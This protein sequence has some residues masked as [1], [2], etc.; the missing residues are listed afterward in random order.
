MKKNLCAAALCLLLLAGCG[1]S[2]EETESPTPGQALESIAA[3]PETMK[4]DV[5]ESQLIQ[6]AL[7]PSDAQET[8]LIWASS[9]RKVAVVDEAGRVSALAAGS[10][11]VTVASEAYSDVSCYVEVIVGEE[12][13]ESQPE[14]SASSQDVA[15]VEETNAASVYPTYYLSEGE[16]AAM[17]D[18]EIQFVINQ[19]YAK[20]GYVFKNQAIQTYFSRMPWYV[21]VSSNTARLHMSSLDRSNINLL[22]RCR[23]EG[24]SSSQ[25]LGWMWTRRMVDQ[26]LSADYVRNLSSYDVQ[27]L[28]N[29]IYAKNGYIF[30]T[31]S[32]QLMFEG[33]SWYQGATRDISRLSFSATD[34]ANIKL[35]SGYR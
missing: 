14:Q 12:E 11:T 1:A 21:P 13:G 25:S 15:Y 20:N 34:K 6:V 35:L 10:C 18:E 17:G 31:D 3:Y 5:G 24:A 26:P 27:L 2:L 23:G 32:L 22:A 30:E 16:V 19:I 29:T 9:D 28:I 8:G 33:Q 4:L 7:T